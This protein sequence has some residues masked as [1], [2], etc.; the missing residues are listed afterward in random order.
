MRGRFW[1]RGCI[2]LKLNGIFFGAAVIIVIVTRNMNPAEYKRVRSAETDKA[3]IEILAVGLKTF[4]QK[5]E[6]SVYCIVY[7]SSPWQASL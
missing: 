3:R 2:E 6:I 1:H 4:A 7:I 5:W